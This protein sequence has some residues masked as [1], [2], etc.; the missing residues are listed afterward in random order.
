MT[1][2][3]QGVARG[4]GAGHVD[5]RGYGTG[6]AAGNTVVER[7]LAVRAVAAAAWDAEDAARLLELLGLDAAEGKI[8]EGTAA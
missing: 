1:V 4:V 7:R 8:N 3:K 6:A 2:N 5:D